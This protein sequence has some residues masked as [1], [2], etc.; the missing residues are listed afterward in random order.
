MEFWDQENIAKT[1]HHAYIIE[2]A[3]DSALP[4]LHGLFNRLQFPIQNNPDFYPLTYKTFS[5]NDARDLKKSDAEK[6]SG[7]NRKIFVISFLSITNEAQHALL[8]TLEEPQVNTH[9]F[10]I[11]PRI[12]IFLPTVLSRV[13]I[14]HT[15]PL[16]EA[17]K[18]A[19]DFLRSTP[20]L[21]IAQ[22]TKL[23]AKYKNAEDGEELKAAVRALLSEVEAIVAKDFNA[24]REAANKLK[25]ID[26]AR[27]YVGDR[28]ASVKI[29][30]EH[31]ALTL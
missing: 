22:V 8:K 18:A 23:I 19:Q 14:V 29:I 25:L 30:L 1:L 16:Y 26:Q 10:I 13:Q 9:F 27:S 12:D 5:I 3:Y 21:R 7:A 31:L 17:S 15:D 4:K 24:S 28:G 2:G 11:T 20:P 6:S